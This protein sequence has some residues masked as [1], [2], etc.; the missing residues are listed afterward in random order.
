M[1][2]A[3]CRL[4]RPP[5]VVRPVPGLHRT[6]PSPDVITD[7]RSY[8]PSVLVKRERGPGADHL[9]CSLLRALRS[10]PRRARSRRRG[11]W[12]DVSPN[13]ARRPRGGGVHEPRRQRSERHRQHPD[14]DP[15]GG[16]SLRPAGWGATA[17]AVIRRADHQHGLVR[18][19][20]SP[21]TLLHVIPAGSQSRGAIVLRL[22]IRLSPGVVSR[23]R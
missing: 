8:P 6:L 18:P 9:H 10:R 21:E 15:S 16:A 1:M 2:A 4:R 20:W 22:L 3:G 19:H 7:M 5:P 13:S 14:T 12:D 17:T 11:N 23:R